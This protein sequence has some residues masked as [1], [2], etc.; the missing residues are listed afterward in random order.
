MYALTLPNTCS[1]LIRIQETA[2]SALC[3]AESAVSSCW[4]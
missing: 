3:P 4:I 2:D 1:T